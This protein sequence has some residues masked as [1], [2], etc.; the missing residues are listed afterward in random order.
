MRRLFWLPVL[1]GLVIASGCGGDEPPPFDTTQDEGPGD[2]QVDVGADTKDTQQP[3][4]LA[5]DNMIPD[6]GT[7]LVQDEGPTP[8]ARNSDCVDAPIA[9]GECQ[10]KVCDTKIGQCVAGWDSEC[11]MKADFFEEDFENGID[12]WTVLDPKPGDQVSWA[13]SAHRKAFGSQS[14]YFGNTKCHTYYSGALNA[15]CEPV[16]P[17]QADSASVRATLTSPYF[18][19]PPISAALS[20]V[21]VSAYIW[22]ESEPM[23]ASFPPEAQLDQFRMSIVTKT[24]EVESSETVM[25]SMTDV[26]YKNTKGQFIYVSAVIT[27]YVGKEIAIRLLFDSIEGANNFYEG[28]YIDNIRVSSSCEPQC[29][30]G[31]ECAADEGECSDDSCQAFLNKTNGKGTCSYPVIPT[32]VEPEC[33]PATVDTKCP[34]D[35]PCTLASCVDGACI[36]TEQPDDQCCRTVDRLDVGF[37]DGTLSGFDAWAYLG[38]DQ[39]KWQPSSFRS[40]DGTWSLY[41]GDLVSRTYATGTDFNHGEATSPDIEIPVDDFAF[42]TFDLWL[43]TEFDGMNKAEYYN[44]AQFDY[45]SVHVVERYGQPTELM[46]PVWSAHSVQSTTGGEFIP[47]GVDLSEWAGKVVRVQFRFESGSGQFNDFE[48][49]Y[50]DNVKVV[51]DNCIQRECQSSPDCGVDGVCKVGGCVDNKCQVSIAGATGCCSV[52]QDCDDQDPCSTDGCVNNVCLHEAV[53]KPGCCFE[54][55]RGSYVFDIFGDLDGFAVVNSS[56][57]GPDGA[58]VSWVLTDLRANSGDRSMYFGNVDTGNYNNGGISR[59]TA[60]SPEIS[61]P[62]SGDYKLSFY[63]YVDVRT[64][65]TKDLFKVDV[66]DGLTP[67]TVFSKVAV[68][69]AAYRNWFQVTGLDLGAFKGKTVKLRFSFDSVDTNPGTNQGLFVDDILVQRECP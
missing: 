18:Y 52:T 67:T 19:V 49:V 50:V 10:K 28:V 55:V 21:I 30:A 53:E 69:T 14:A 42:L 45:F 20:T 16:D 41:Y 65:T 1:T 37:E 54:D 48:G 66:M 63:V 4:D 15:E 57:P 58:D 60:T 7:D 40:S 39:V 51:S 61:V 17:A 33:T 46:T 6:E 62:A 23:I 43:S 35:D 2:I 68:P 22:V 25:T 31:T 56:T 11:C 59:G 5:V 13:A 36:Y 29:D 26:I 64:D 32:C 3:P 27:P 8:C 47:V 38:E 9:L 44:P 24:G 34:T 12:A